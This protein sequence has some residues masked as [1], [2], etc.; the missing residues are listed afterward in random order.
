MVLY[1]N[2]IY[3]TPM[4]PTNTETT[5]L[6]AWDLYEETTVSTPTLQSTFASVETPPDSLHHKL[7]QLDLFVI[8]HHRGSF[9]PKGMLPPSHLE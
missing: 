7:L 2:A 5:P 1:P 4:K 9:L 3:P 6:T 8:G